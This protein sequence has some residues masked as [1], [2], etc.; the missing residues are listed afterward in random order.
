MCSCFNCVIFLCKKL[1]LC[2][3]EHHALKTHWEM[4]VE[5]HALI[6]SALD[7]V[8]WSASRPSRFT[9]TEVRSPR[10]P[11]DRRLCRPERLCTWRLTEK[12]VPL[13][14]IRSLCTGSAT[15]SSKFV[16]TEKNIANNFVQSYLLANVLNWCL[17]ELDAKIRI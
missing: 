17:C 14:D 3:F 9:P 1:F 4:A 5:L 7:I 13:S 8:R 10:D 12:S 15:S 2:L 11:L 16:D 6:S